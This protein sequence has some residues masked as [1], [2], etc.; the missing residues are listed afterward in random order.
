MQTQQAMCEGGQ[1]G[2]A[3]I[4]YKHVLTENQSSDGYPA[5]AVTADNQ[6][7]VVWQSFLHGHDR[8]LAKAFNGGT[9]SESVMISEPGGAFRPQ[10]AVTGS[11]RLGVVWSELRNG[12]SNLRARFYDGEQW[13]PVTQVTD[14]SDA[15]YA[16]ICGDAGIGFWVVWSG[17]GRHS[18][19]C[20]RY[21]DGATWA[22]SVQITDLGT[23]YR[24]AIAVDSQ[25]NPWV[26][27]DAFRDGK[28]DVFA[29]NYDGTS[30]SDVEKLSASPNW[31]GTT[32]ACSDG[33][34][35]I[36]VLWDEIG[37]QA[38]VSY[39]LRYFDGQQ[40][41]EPLVIG[42]IR[43]WC[44]YSALTVS[45]CRR[46]Y[47]AYNW[48]RGIHVRTVR[49][50]RLLEPVPIHRFTST[51]DRYGR[52]PSIAV[53]QSC[54][55]WI[56]WQSSY[57][58]DCHP[59]N[60][61]VW[62][63]ALTADQLAESEDQD[64]ERTPYAFLERPYRRK[65][66]K[67]RQAHEDN[68]VQTEGGNMGYA[69]YRIFWGD[70]HGQATLSDGLGEVD[71]YYRALMYKAM[72][73]FGALSEHDAFPDVV[74]GSE[75]E[76]LQ[77]GST[78]FNGAC[79]FVTL[80][81]Y[82]WTS[83]ESTSGDA[84]YGHRN[85]YYPADRGP[86]LRCTEPKSD[87]PDKL[88][89]AIG[90][91]RGLVF[92]HHPAVGPT[93]NA[94]VDWDYHDPEIQRVVEIF[95]IHGAFECFGNESP[96]SKNVSQIPGHSW[97]DALQ[98]G[99]KL[100]VIGGS[101][102]HQME[103]GIEGG[104]TAAYAR[105]LTRRDLFE[106][107]YARHVYATTGARIVLLFSVDGS[108]MGSEVRGRAG[109]RLFIHLA[110][111]GSDRINRIEVLKDNVVLAA[112]HGRGEVEHLQVTDVEGSEFQGTRWYYARVAQY[113]GHMAWSSPIWVAYG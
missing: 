109:E 28:Y 77:I 5:V 112:K 56:A 13:T 31:C 26:C 49:D 16:D 36:W 33:N 89:E 97:Q 14:S 72:V 91:S 82:E 68:F 108:I 57:G 24:P 45:P 58:N 25:G 66:V 41:L 51:K 54:A 99:H 53:D 74:T 8:V 104:L 38:H 84:R 20:V 80:T 11:N 105:Q 76:L 65:I 79:D 42:P 44:A 85:V 34:G 19:V 88:F 64:A 3:M 60:A 50:D 75:W 30:W 103:A 37:E 17:P 32:K 46:P 7:W 12:H 40:W 83:S 27:F 63:Q 100:G 90:P 59:R 107:L 78:S 6:V 23:A 21:Y 96:Y 2:E 62:I 93:W 70:I 73:D 47:V 110:V 102:T 81:G 52:R 86:L 92:P 113:D 29:L 111:R 9:W 15:C 67:S 69:G 95:S 1:A 18:D 106:A 10:V 35:G 61:D 43:G 98:H 71:Q 22:P 94:A 4:G 101:D 39:G 87:T 48:R 55:L